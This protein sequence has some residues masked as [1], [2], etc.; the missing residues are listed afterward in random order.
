MREADLAML[1]PNA[2]IY[3]EDG[4]RLYSPEEQLLLLQAERAT[5]SARY[6]PQHPDLIKLTRTIQGLEAFIR[7]RRAAGLPTGEKKLTAD[8]WEVLSRRG[9]KPAKDYTIRSGDSFWS[10][11]RQYGTN[12]REL[13]KAN[14]MS[15]TDSLRVGR[16]LVV[17][18]AGDTASAAGSYT[19]NNPD[20]RRL[21][22][23]LNATDHQPSASTPKRETVPL[24]REIGDN[25][26]YLRV[27]AEVDS[28]TRELAQVRAREA[29]LR[30]TIGQYEADLERAP[31]VER[32]FSELQRNREAMTA[33]LARIEE[34]QLDAKLEKAID[35]SDT[36]GRF[37]LAEPVSV[38]AKPD[39]PNRA[40][41]MLLSVLLALA[42]GSGFILAGQLRREVIYDARG[43]QKAL[44]ILPLV[45]IPDVGRKGKLFGWLGRSRNEAIA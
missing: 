27:R 20:V 29:E 25:P 21:N 40:V 19:D 32:Q 18:P 15:P 2:A 30:A 36:G 31:E 24:S 26:S 4:T 6:S 9:D 23:K 38:P 8:E 37:A 39:K 12:V 35:N 3:S 7:E 11:A 16:K 34:K 41:L 42:G 14:G 44:G 5:K 33:Q 10:I 43:L 45:V 22:R 1:G 13:A 17:L 28:V